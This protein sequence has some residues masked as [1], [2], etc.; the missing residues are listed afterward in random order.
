ML[1]ILLTRS[2]GSTLKKRNRPSNFKG[3]IKQWHRI[4]K[5]LQVY[6]DERMW[7]QWRGLYDVIAYF[8]L[9]FGV[10]VATYGLCGLKF[11]KS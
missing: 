7:R 1:I 6:L 10:S 9:V 2:A 3:P 11:F 5:D 4:P 8:L